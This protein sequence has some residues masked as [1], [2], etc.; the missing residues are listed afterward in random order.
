MFKNRHLLDLSQ[1]YVDLKQQS[2]LLT[3]PRL[4]ELNIL[5]IVN[6]RQHIIDLSILVAKSMVHKLTLTNLPELEATCISVLPSLVRAKGS[7]LT[8]ST[9]KSTMVV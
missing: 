7:A 2:H 9:S 5:R 6:Q 3:N 4:P 8:L 1:A